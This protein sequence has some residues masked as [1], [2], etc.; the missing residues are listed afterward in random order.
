MFSWCEW[1]LVYVLFWSEIRWITPWLPSWGK[2]WYAGRLYI[3]CLA[4]F[5][6]LLYCVT[7]Q[8]LT[9][10]QL[11]SYRRYSVPRKEAQARWDGSRAAVCYMKT[12]GDESGSD[13]RVMNGSHEWPEQTKTMPRTLKAKTVV[14]ATTRY[15]SLG[16]LLHFCHRI[17]V[18]FRSLSQRFK[19][20]V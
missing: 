5:R 9:R 19:N 18:I 10:P 20:V 1:R 4:S 15:S 12:T 6:G 2:L 13:S 17:I 3:V 8:D 7:G 16:E 14:T 11:S